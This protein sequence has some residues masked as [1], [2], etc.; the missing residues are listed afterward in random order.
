VLEELNRIESAA[1]FVKV[2]EASKGVMTQLAKHLGGT[3]PLNAYVPAEI[4]ED[5]LRMVK[6]FSS[7]E[8]AGAVVGAVDK[9]TNAFKVSALARP[10][11]ILRDF[12]SGQFMNWVSGL[13]SPQSLADA[14]QIMTKGL[15]A[16][17]SGADQIFKDMTPQQ[18]TQQLVK[19][20]FAQ[21]IVQPFGGEFNDLV[22][23]G[24]SGSKLLGEVPGGVPMTA[25]GA[26]VEQWKQEGRFNPLRVRGVGMPGQAANETQFAVA[27][28]FENAASYSDGLNRIAPYIE[29]RRMGMTPEV[30][31]RKVKL[32]QVDYSALTSTERSVLK[33]VLPF[34]TFTKK[35]T[36]VVLN[37]LIEK[38]GGRLAQ[39]IRAE[40]ASRDDQFLPP[41]LAPGLAIR[42]PE[43]LGPENGDTRFLTS[44]DL[45]RRI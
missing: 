16:V 4:K 44:I 25:K 41:Y 8:P 43:S 22:A 24:V 45:P 42:L 11:R 30:A 14:H 19:E 26:L 13:F 31:A 28:M 40:N 38:P 5:A 12:Y 35:M 18:A 2:D 6:G 33:R 23:P 36:P 20:L 32:A 3:N 15:D 17:V 21:K 10:S 39:T 7:P 29:A 34:Y 27:K 1:D 37:E 9:F